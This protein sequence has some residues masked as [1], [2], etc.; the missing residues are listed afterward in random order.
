MNALATNAAGSERSHAPIKSSPRDVFMYLLVIL[1]LYVTVSEVLVALF[2]YIDLLLPRRRDIDCRE[3]L[4]PRAGDGLLH[5][6]DRPGFL[7]TAGR[8][9]RCASREHGC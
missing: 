2:S 1:M 7:C 5:A 4:E 6:H 8:P 9:R 3:Q